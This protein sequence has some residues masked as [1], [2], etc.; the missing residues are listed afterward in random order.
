MFSH[1]NNC[2]QVTF[3]EKECWLMS[4]SDRSDKWL[5]DAYLNGDQQSFEVL[6]ERYRRP[7]YSY[8]NKMLPSQ[9][10]TVDDL[11]QKTWMKAIKNL[12][13]YQDRQTFYAWLVR[14]A[15]NNAIDLF[16]KEQKRQSVDIEDI[17]LADKVGEPWKDMANSELG[18]AIQEAVE[19][20]PDEQKEVFLLRQ[21]KIAFKDI[22]EIQ[23]CTLN[24]VLG[25]MHY[26]TNRLRVL[27]REWK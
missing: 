6:Y 3:S 14:I 20:L 15:H 4:E 11:Y 22:A 2:S 12:G 19:Q 10:S 16:R 26:A 1:H 5:I 9:S 7:L 23:G 8:L 27:L 24:T 25:R 18:K 17:P 21:D 13:R